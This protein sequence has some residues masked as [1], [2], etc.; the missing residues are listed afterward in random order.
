M[1]LRVLVLPE[2][3]ECSALQLRSSSICSSNGSHNSRKPRIAS[4]TNARSSAEIGVWVG[5][6]GG[7]R[8]G[9]AR[10]RSHDRSGT[11]GT[12]AGPARHGLCGRWLSRLVA[13]AAEKRLT[14]R[15]EMCGRDLLAFWWTEFRV[16]QQICCVSLEQ[17]SKRE[18]HRP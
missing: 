1:G 8:S 15:A 10:G 2:L 4:R 5:S 7:V 18:G 3:R 11:P 14:L 9:D 13:T 6:G 16:Q 12:S 17:D